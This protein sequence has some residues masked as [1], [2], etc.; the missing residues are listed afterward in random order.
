MENMIVSYQHSC[1]CICVLCEKHNTGYFAHFK[2][3]TNWLRKAIAIMNKS[4]RI[5]K[6]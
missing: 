2:E 6:E 3:E 4:N 5:S 1:E